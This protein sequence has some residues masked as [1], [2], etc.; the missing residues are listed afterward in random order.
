MLL[1]WLVVVDNV[2]TISFKKDEGTWQKQQCH[3]DN[4]AELFS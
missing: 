4:I 2:E 1:G 3:H